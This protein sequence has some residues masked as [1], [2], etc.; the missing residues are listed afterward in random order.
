MMAANERAQIASLGPND[1]G[2]EVPMGDIGSGSF[3]RVPEALELGHKAAEARRDDLSRYSVS[4]DQY[5]AWLEKVGKGAADTPVLADVKIVGLQ[6][7]NVDYV[8]A[9][10]QRIAP[11]EI[12]LVEAPAREQCVG[13]RE[14]HVRGGQRRS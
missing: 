9:Q 5:H 11:G 12:A 3:E 14:V 2:I 13:H 10:L 4:D 1:I 8:R 7:V 6:R